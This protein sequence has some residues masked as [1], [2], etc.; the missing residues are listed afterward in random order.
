MA[1]ERSSPTVFLCS[2]SDARM[3]SRFRSEKSRGKFSP[4]IGR[5]SKQARHAQFE[6]ILGKTPSGSNPGRGGAV[7]LKYMYIENIVIVLT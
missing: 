2:F 3:R 4:L 7:K 5:D 6:L 1:P